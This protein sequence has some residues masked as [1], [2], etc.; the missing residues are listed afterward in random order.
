MAVPSRRDGAHT[1]ARASGV[2][3]SAPPASADQTD[4]LSRYEGKDIR[5]VTAEEARS[6]TENKMAWTDRWANQNNFRYWVERC[7]A[8]MEPQGV[9][10]RQLFY[11]GYLAYL[12]ADF[13]RAADTYREGLDLWKTVLANYPTYRDDDLNRK[14]TGQAV[15]RYVEALRQAGR[16]VPE[17]MPF[18]DLLED[19]EL[20]PMLDPFDAL[21]M[22]GP[23]GEAEQSESNP[24]GPAGSL[25]PP[26]PILSAA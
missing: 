15:L 6:L 25:C 23:I 26:P 11:E 20:D 1:D 22:L 7:R 24:S 9:R 2:K 4:L 8:E 19:A 5:E 10:A 14:D 12:D 16:E 21:D 17:D 13:P 18:A 3:A